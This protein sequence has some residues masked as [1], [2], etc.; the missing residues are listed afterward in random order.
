[1]KILKRLIGRYFQEA[2]FLATYL[3]KEQDA[4][5]KEK[6]AKAALAEMETGIEKG[7]ESAFVL[8]IPLDIKKTF[9]QTCVESTC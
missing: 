9:N 8:T 6:S 3:R 5:Q 7:I 2:S 1:M 4:Y